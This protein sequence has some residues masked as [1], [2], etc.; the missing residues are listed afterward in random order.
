VSQCAKLHVAG[1]THSFSGEVYDF[2]SV[3][4]EYFGCTIVVTRLRTERFGVR[5]LAGRTFCSFQ[6]VQTVS[7]AHP[8]SYSVDTDFS[9]RGRS[10]RNVVLTT[11]HLASRLRM[12][13]A[14]PLLLHAFMAWTWKIYILRILF[15]DGVLCSLCERSVE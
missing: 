9:S 7:R 2:Y 1:C 11:H 6:N 8:S 14:I 4:P 12:S 3:S 5:N 15:K 13:G 10:G